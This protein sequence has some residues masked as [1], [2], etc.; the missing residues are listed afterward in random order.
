LSN[1]SP[2]L[3]VALCTYNGTRYLPE[4]L[5][6][7]L[8]Q[9]RLP[10]ELVL[11]DDGSTDDTVA[12]L[13]RWAT[14]V[15]FPV[16]IHPNPANIGSTKS[17]ERAMSLCTGDI[18][19]LSDQDDA[20]REDRLQQTADWFTAHPDMDAVFSDAD[21]INDDS[22]LLGRCI[23]DEVQF[24]P[25]L[26]QQW[27]QG[28]GYELL[29]YGYVVTGATMAV[30]RAVLP[31]LLPFPTHV[32]Y[33]I[34]D[35]WMSLLLAL[36]GTIGFV[37][38]PLIRYRQHSHQQVGFK[39]ARAKVTLTD[40]LR[41]D[42]TERMAPI[43][44]T[45]DRYQKL[46]QLLKAR[47]DIDPDR[48]RLL[49]KMAAHLTRRTRLPEYRLLRLPAVLAELAKGRYQLF[50]GHWWLTVLGDLVEP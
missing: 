7:I 6:S 37:E 44:Q 1:A 28:R 16:H 35:A 10:D 49:G 26:R 30:R 48:I 31:S 18:I 5:A 46:Y 36:K 13:H 40:R 38:A 4:Q 33:L 45:A 50:P 41:R 20:W 29:F 25:N 12:F 17:F 42:R 3:S 23:W 32:P 19:V 24:L 11:V 21:L 2:S 43:L 15:P 9:T 27:R 14:N 39:P 47:T 8:A 34:H 22:N